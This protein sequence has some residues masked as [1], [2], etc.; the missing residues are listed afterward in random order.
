MSLSV[1]L[2]QD[3]FQVRQKC[4]LEM[5]IRSTLALAEGDTVEFQFPN[6]WM[7]VTGPSYTR[8]LQLADPGREH[9]I[10][11]E[12]DGA[13][14]GIDIRKRTL[15]CP[16]GIVRHGRHI[17]ATVTSGTV[18]PGEPIRA[19]Y[20]NTFAPYVAETDTVWVRVKGEQPDE[21]PALN[22][23]PGPAVELRIVAPSGIEPGREFEVL[24]VS[25]DEFENASSTHYANETLGVWG[26]QAVAEGLTFTGSTRVK[27]SLAEE[28][29]YRFCMGQAVSNPVR[30]A[31]GVR[32][33][34]WG[35]IHIHTKISHDGQGND[36]FGYA[37]DV[38]G[39]DFAGTADHCSA[40]GQ[41]GYDQQLAWAEQAY[42]P[43]RF[44]TVLGDER[45]T[46]DFSTERWTN[47][48]HYNVYFR[49]VES[50][51]KYIGQPGEERFVNMLA[52]GRPQIDPAEAMFVPHHTGI[53]WGTEGNAGAVISMD[54]ALAGMG[55]RPVIEIYSHHGQSECYAPQHILSYELNRMRNP[56]RRTNTSRPGPHYAQDYWMAGERL[57]V[58]ASSDEHSGQGGRVHGGIA[59]VWPDE[60]TREGIF[61]AI[62]R[63]RCYGTTGRRIL[64]D[65]SVDGVLTGQEARRKKGSPLKIVLKVWGT[66][67]LLRV[68]ILRFIF[69][70]DKAFTT[71][72]SNAPRP[73]S[74]DG[75]YELQDTVAGPCMYY[76]RVTQE[77]LDWPGM[78]W[79]SPV[80][81]DV[82]G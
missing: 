76:A 26:G 60:L 40:T 16:Q 14:F 2:A 82:E 81:I 31:A 25:V 55:L 15:H 8:L 21:P 80:W 7:L 36:P 1:K 9:Y 62:R 77:P 42:Q 67:L 69:G 74:M 38:S 5:T 57:G 35:D 23:T 17:V 27:V 32:G 22:V 59:A 79:S 41:A 73:E 37:R 10:S 70:T 13:E 45:D 19:R 29:V 3:S 61:D 51:L 53:C 48:G 43:G 52:E 12:A 68:E 46:G 54:D 50:F 63:R 72:L 6:S 18:P 33:P 66:E 65:F 78:A 64:M 56:E 71:V 58:I 34:Y 11:V 30:V 24:V 44:V 4:D 49:S 39:L 28:G 20:A 47:H 75:E